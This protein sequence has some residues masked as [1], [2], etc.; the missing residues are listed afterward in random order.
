M[1]GFMVLG[2]VSLAWS[3]PTVLLPIENGVVDPDLYDS[4]V[5]DRAGLSVVPELLVEYAPGVFGYA[6]DFL[7]PLPNVSAKKGESSRS[8]ENPGLGEGALSGKEVYASQCHGW[9]WF[10][11]LNDFSTQRGNNF[12]TVEDFHNPEGMNQYLAAYL[13]NAGAALFMVKERDL[14]SNVAYA[15]NDGAGYSESGSFSNGA[16]GFAER[17]S[18]SYG[19][20]PFSMGT[21]RK[22]VAD[23]GDV[24]TFIPDVPE[25]GYYTL[26]VTWKNKPGHATD[27]HYRITHLG[28]VIDRWFDQ[29]QHGNTWQY[30]E[31]LWMTAGVESVMVEVIADSKQVGK[32]VSLDAVRVGGGMSV[33]SRHGQVAGRP[34]W[35]EGAILSTQ[36]NGA[37]SWVYDPWNDGNGSDPTS[38][39]L[40]AAW[41]HPRGNDAVY[42]SWHSNASGAG[43]RGTV[44]Y[45]YGLSGCTSGPPT[46]GSTELATYL[47][48]EL[49]DSFT[50]FWDANWNDRGIKDDC[51]A[52]VNPA[53]N[54]EMPSALVELAFHDEEMDTAHLVDP[55]F[56]RDASRAMYRGIVRYFAAESGEKPKYLPEPPI[57]ISVTHNKTGELVADWSSSPFV[58]APYGDA[59][60]S[61]RLYTSA[62]GRAWDN[63]TDV[64][65]LS[66]VLDVNN[67]ERQFVRV[68]GIN[69]GGESFPSVIVG[70]RR[71]SETGSPI[72]VVNAFD[73]EDSGLLRWEEV[74]RLDEVK[75]LDIRQ[76]NPFDAIGVHGRAIAAAG[77]PFDS[78][79]DDAVLDLSSYDLV[80]WAAGEESTVD[81]TLSDAQQ[82]MVRAFVEDGGQFFISG[83]EV[84]WDLDEKG[85]V[86][87][88]A[89]ALEVL[90]ALMEEDDAGTTSAD[91]VGVLSGIVLDFDQLDG[92]PY[93]VEWPDVLETTGEVLATYA[94]GG[95]AAVW[96]DGG[97][98]FGF[99][100]ESIG[101]AQSRVEVMARLLPLL[102]P[103]FTPTEPDTGFETGTTTTTLTTTV[104][105]TETD[106]PEVDPSDGDGDSA[107]CGCNTGSPANVGWLLPLLFMIRRRSTA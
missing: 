79:V 70:G 60:Q 29:T 61:Y 37:P 52:E 95:V 36:T 4:A 42:L 18:Y 43:A 92:A 47:Q 78:A 64:D 2:V 25:D 10:D 45:T 15:D 62:D 85:D 48:D 7:P 11:S 27:V 93:P 97:M 58:G 100:F 102:V 49:I 24:A 51:F 80:I 20:N 103:D 17:E 96:T 65:G 98:V 46:E 76:L 59:T 89:F 6:R 84:L 57:D 67:G 23:S 14:N 28:G 86:E 101:S 35:E 74:P 99:P 44:T 3:A 83:A 50:T 1:N 40:W 32:M 21:T 106:R 77:W 72:L 12:D 41:E 75:R 19:Q 69:E 31:T 53:Y 73:R 107:N 54:N 81:E 71:A 8:L 82:E 16:A 22:M 55:R 39:S 34:R 66:A 13:E 9:I 68:T 63:G 88:Q 87:D 33:V 94:T 5:E 105:V 104:T 91:G 26:Y 90:G 38:R 30:V 56:R